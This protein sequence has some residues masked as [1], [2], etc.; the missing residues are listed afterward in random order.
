MTDIAPVPLSDKEKNKRKCIRWSKT[1]T[2]PSWGK[3]PA[4]P[5]E[6]TLAN[7]SAAQLPAGCLR[8][9]TLPAEPSGALLG[10]TCAAPSAGSPRCHGP[11][12]S[13]T[14]PQ[15]AASKPGLLT[16]ANKDTVDSAG[17]GRAE[18]GAGGSAPP[19]SRTE[20]LARLGDATGGRSRRHSRRADPTG[21]AAR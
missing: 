2:N 16:S 6:S 17:G 15:R 13:K 11:G 9:F 10:L 8:C 7:I 21:V 20:R 18:F 12:L 5:A 1:N 14:N 3:R 4:E 19:R